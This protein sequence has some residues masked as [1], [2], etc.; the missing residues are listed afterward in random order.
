[1]ENGYYE[2][3]SVIRFVAIVVYIGYLVNV[4]LLFIVVPWSQV[5]GLLL[6]R[7][8][9]QL[10]EVLGLPSVRG[11]LSAFGVLHLTLVL[12]ELIHPTLL[13]P[14]QSSENGS[15]NQTES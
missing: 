12:W 5:W 8:P 4:G 9:M 10:A 13:T 6:T 11:A 1:V 15:Q 2:V 3:V 14:I 7:C